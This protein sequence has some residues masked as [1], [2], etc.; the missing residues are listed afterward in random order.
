MPTE[1]MKFSTVTI[2]I[3]LLL[4]INLKNNI[5]RKKLKRKLKKVEKNMN[6]G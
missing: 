3:E 1:V 4:Y 2:Y 5:S 6:Y